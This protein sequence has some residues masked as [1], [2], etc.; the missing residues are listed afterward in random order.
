MQVEIWSDVVCPW[1]Y[2]GRHRFDR[3][4]AAVAPPQP[5]EVVLRSFELDPGATGTPEAPVVEHLIQRYGMSR[6]EAERAIEHVTREARTEGLE[7]RLDLA[8]PSNTLDAHRLLQLARV[9]HRRPEVEERFE[10]AYFRE[11]AVLSDP[12][13]LLEL[14]TEAGLSSEDVRRVLAGQAFTLQVRFDEEEATRA[15]ATGV[16]HFRFDDGRTISG[17]QPF[18]V[19]VAAL[20]ALGSP[21]HGDPGGAN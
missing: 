20:R 15:G 18:S 6:S 8:R 16:P 5:P 12:G 11:G 19:F 10:R 14:S 1:C 3:A 9:R 4:L 7:L 21:R 13:T 17:A 2:L